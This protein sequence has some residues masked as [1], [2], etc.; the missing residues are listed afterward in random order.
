MQNF[1]QNPFIVIWETTQACDLAC[2]HCRA[3]ARP[4]R[5]AHELSTAEART[6]LNDVRALSAP[7][8]V[9]TG[10][11]PLKRP[12]LF[13]LLAYSV[14]IGLRTAVTPSAT[15][16][17]TV[18]AIAGFKAAG[19]SRMAVSLDGPDEDIHDSFRQVAGSFERTVF[20]LGEARRIGLETQVNITVGPHNL[21]TLAKI[22]KLVAESGAKLWSVFFLVP[23]GRAKSIADLTATEYEEV[24]DVLYGISRIAPFD[25]K[26]TEAPHYR[27]Y[28]L[29]RREGAHA[30]PA[31]TS[32]VEGAGGVND[33]KGLLFISH[34]GDICPSGFLPIAAGNIRHDAI[35]EVYRNSPLFRELRDS[36][37]LEGKCG[38]CLYRNLCGGSRARA[39]AM[40]G[41]LHAP[42]PKCNYEPC[43]S[44]R[45]REAAAVAG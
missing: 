33:G 1:D 36:R 30:E 20:A 23:V 12:D 27:R 19:V 34:T 43:R 9:F 16:L 25:I 24:F 10:G 40:T 11:D 8:M 17:L 35:A 6:M 21:N 4:Y 28:V 44:M 15:P 26:T 32:R 13:E 3:N 41:D 14:H 38:D 2:V 37:Y 22:A 7:L 5:D 29:Q 42:D 45:A 31:V 39:F 18:E